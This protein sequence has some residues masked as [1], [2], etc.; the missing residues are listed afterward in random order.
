MTSAQQVADTWLFSTLDAALSVPVSTHP[1]PGEADPPYVTF[2]P[3]SAIDILTGNDNRI[4]T[5]YRYLVRAIDR[6]RS[7]PFALADA[8]D[9]ALNRVRGSAAGGQVIACVRAAPFSVAEDVEGVEYRH[10]G[11][12][13]TIIVTTP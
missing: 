10:I 6:G 4:Q 12:E 2:T 8:V 13:Y 5:E 7:F 11:G 1:A 9:A 3:V